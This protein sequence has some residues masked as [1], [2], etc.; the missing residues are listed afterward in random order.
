M[1]PASTAD[2]IDQA[3]ARVWGVAPTLAACLST[4]GGTARILVRCPKLILRVSNFN[5]EQFCSLSP[6]R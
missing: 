2:G 6:E 3:M 4:S 1:T 5:G